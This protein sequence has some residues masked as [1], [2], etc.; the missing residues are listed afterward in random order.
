MKFYGP[1]NMLLR[2]RN[3]KPIR[4]IRFDLNGE[5]ETNNPRLTRRL[6]ARF[7]YEEEG[8][9]VQPVQKSAEENASANIC[10]CKKCGYEAENKG[11]LL[12]HYRT[13]HKKE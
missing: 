9:A 3:M 5:Y 4:A 11:K 7:R 6:K 12:A 2:V 8:Q 13:A 10:I 1:P